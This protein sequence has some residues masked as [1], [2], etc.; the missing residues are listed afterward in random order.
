M[1]LATKL[2]A[3]YEALNF[4]KEDKK[5]VM[6]TIVTLK[7]VPS[8]VQILTKD[9]E[10]KKLFLSDDLMSIIKGGKT[11]FSGLG[12]RIMYHIKQTGKI[13]RDKNSS[14]LSVIPNAVSHR[15]LKAL[16]NDG[17]NLLKK[18]K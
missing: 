4:S 17:V 9:K 14:P 5:S 10:G 7:N 1:K 16:D 6:S 2:L 8:V 11:D 18:A 12:K 13:M 15:L 3:L